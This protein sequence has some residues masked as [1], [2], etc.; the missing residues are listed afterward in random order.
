MLETCM[1]RRKRILPYNRKSAV[2]YA[3]R[4][5]YHR[6]PL[7]YDFEKVGGDCTNFVSQCLYA[8]SGVMNYTPVYGWYYSS[9]YQ[10]TASW[11][12]VDFL[13]KFLS[14]NQGPG[15]FAETTEVTDVQPG[16]IIQLSFTGDGVYHHSVMVV[17]TGSPTTLENILTACHTDDRDYYPMTE[18]IWKEIR[19]LHIVGVGG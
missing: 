3:H 11:T 12:G 8:G 10:R 13:F 19:F 5:A 2:E 6:N 4:W 16:D 14:E 17:Q 15:P 1:Q 7:Y 9:A 18:Y